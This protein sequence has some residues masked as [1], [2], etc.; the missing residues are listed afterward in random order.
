MTVVTMQHALLPF[1]FQVTTF[2]AISLLGEGSNTSRH[3][4]MQEEGYCNQ[5]N[6]N[7]NSAGF[8][9]FQTSAL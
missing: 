2:H 6:I 1:S 7:V 9:L 4:E 5:E 8:K 3:V